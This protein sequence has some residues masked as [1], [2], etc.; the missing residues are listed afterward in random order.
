MLTEHMNILVLMEENEKQAN[1]C[2]V[3]DTTQIVV[4]CSSEK[5]RSVVQ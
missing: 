5:F 3:L 2:Q 1:I 4:V